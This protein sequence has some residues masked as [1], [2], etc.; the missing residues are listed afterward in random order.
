MVYNIS[1]YEYI[2]LACI[3]CVRIW[4][5]I[6][7]LNLYL[8]INHTSLKNFCNLYITFVICNV[9]QL[10]NILVLNRANYTWLECAALKNLLALDGS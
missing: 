5:M 3:M 7:I 2:Y 4:R 6:I 8:V 9:H 1:Y 10:Q